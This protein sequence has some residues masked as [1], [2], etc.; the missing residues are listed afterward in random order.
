MPHLSVAFVKSC[1]HSLVFLC[2][3]IMLLIKL[4]TSCRCFTLKSDRT[5]E[6][7][8]PLN[9]WWTNKIYT[10]SLRCDVSPPKEKDLCTC[11]GE[12]ICYRL[13]KEASFFM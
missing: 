1:F 4:N 7:F 3:V 6:G 9:C 12:R 11:A 10:V 13:L 2:C 5:R 8:W